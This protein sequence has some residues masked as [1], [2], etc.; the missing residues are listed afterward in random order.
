MK[1]AVITL[2]VLILL[3][4]GIFASVRY[5][6]RDLVTVQTSKIVKADLN[7]VVTASGEIK[8]KT[9]INLG[10]VSYTHLRAHET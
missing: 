3:G 6:K 1:K 4:G 2:I 5:T 9:Y 7:Q 8:P 10:A